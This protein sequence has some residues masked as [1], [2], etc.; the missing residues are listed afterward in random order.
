MMSASQ[1]ETKSNSFV[2]F[3]VLGEDACEDLMCSVSGN[4]IGTQVDKTIAETEAG[5]QTDCYAN[6][7]CSYYTFNAAEQFCLHYS[8]C[9]SVSDEFCPECLS[10]QPACI[11][12]GGVIPQPPDNPNP[13]IYNYVNKFNNNFLT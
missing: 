10:G 6:A 12:D 8:E 13:G 11:V 7:A 3:I 2:R 1:R 9:P 4:C 5:C